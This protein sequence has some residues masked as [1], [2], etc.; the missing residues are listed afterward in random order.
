MNFLI[1][2]LITMITCEEATVIRPDDYCNFLPGTTMW[3]TFETVDSTIVSIITAGNGDGRMELYKGD[4]NS[5][6]YITEDDDSGPFLM[7]QI[8]YTTSPN[9]TYYVKVT[10]V[11]LF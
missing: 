2:L 3:Y 7:P 11:D 8:Q 6:E 9:T 4:C 5:L 1:A 10:G